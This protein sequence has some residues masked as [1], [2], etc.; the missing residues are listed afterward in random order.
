MKSPRNVDIKTINIKSKPCKHVHSTHKSRQPLYP[1]TYLSWQ[2]FA[3]NQE[4]ILYTVPNY[5]YLYVCMSMKKMCVC[6]CMSLCINHYNCKCIAGVRAITKMI[7]CIHTYMRESLARYKGIH[8]RV[9]VR[10]ARTQLMGWTC[11]RVNV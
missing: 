10:I 3:N 9:C 4:C 1:P 11:K 5:V 7:P 6:V 2:S 8:M